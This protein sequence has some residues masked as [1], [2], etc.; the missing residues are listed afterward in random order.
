MKELI[1]TIDAH[2]FTCS[3][4]GV[5]ALIGLYL[6]WNGLASAIRAWRKGSR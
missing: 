1:E 5:M 3:M 6:S 2:G 4:I